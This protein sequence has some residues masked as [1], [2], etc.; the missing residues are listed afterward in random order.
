VLPC[1]CGSRRSSFGRV[2]RMSF[3]MG[4]VTVS[5]RATIPGRR[6]G[7]SA[8]TELDRGAQ[9]AARQQVTFWCSDNHETTL[10]FA[11]GVDVPLEWT[12]RECGGPASQLP[13]EA[14]S[15]VPESAFFR[16]PYEFLMMR[17]TE[18]EGEALLEEALADLARR[19]GASRT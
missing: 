13:G 7:S 3:S 9:L 8:S 2:V 10:Y 14:R 18:E 1:R 6:I 15:A 16:T 19:R 5:R 4:R 17:R 11:E 12:C